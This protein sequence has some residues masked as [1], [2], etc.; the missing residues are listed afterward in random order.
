M[1]CSG[2]GYVPSWCGHAPL[3]PLRL[4]NHYAGSDGIDSTIDSVKGMVVLTGGSAQ[5]QPT[6]AMGALI[7]CIL[8][9][10]RHQSSCTGAGIRLMV[11]V[12]CFQSGDGPGVIHV[13]E[14]HSQCPYAPVILPGDKD[15]AIID[16]RGVPV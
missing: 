14:R 13:R 9:G 15:D 3:Y 1:P 16:M 8:G 7:D 12:F 11:W 5:S 2:L 6:A 4:D 10:Y